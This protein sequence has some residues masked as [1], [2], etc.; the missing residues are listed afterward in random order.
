MAKSA[1]R[2]SGSAGATAKT[3]SNPARSATPPTSRARTVAKKSVAKTAAGTV[4]SNKALLKSRK[5]PYRSPAHLA[6]L[7]TA[8]AAPNVPEVTTREKV[9][10]TI[11]AVVMEEVR[12]RAASGQISAYVTRAVQHQLDRDNLADLLAEM[13]QVNGPV[14][15]AE[16]EAA[17]AQWP[18]A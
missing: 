10:L 1:K 11:P 9:S 7:R 18:T 8:P 17:L 6:A 2:Q 13:E 15:E 4:R 12:G 5:S 14:T 16:I 3:S